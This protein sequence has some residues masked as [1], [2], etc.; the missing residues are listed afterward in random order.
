MKWIWCF[1]IVSFTR[2]LKIRR[3]I[4]IGSSLRLTVCVIRPNPCFFRRHIVSFPPFLAII[5][6]FLSCSCNEWH[7]TNVS[8]QL[9][10]TDSVTWSV[11]SFEISQ[12]ELK[13][14]NKVLIQTNHSMK[15]KKFHPFVCFL[16]DPLTL[17]LLFRQSATAEVLTAWK[18]QIMRIE[19]SLLE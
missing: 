11:L 13:M 8:P 10:L 2:S 15:E 6:V 12:P 14:I 7:D 16:K 1:F 9:N 17:V 5:V 4:F 19:R 3:Y 18:K